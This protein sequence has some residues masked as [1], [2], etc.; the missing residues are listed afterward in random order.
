MSLTVDQLQVAL[1]GKE[2]LHKIQLHMEE[3]EFL[4]LIGAS[5]CGKTT[6]LKSIAGLLEVQ[7]GDIRIHG[8]SVLEKAPEKRGTVI[9]FQDLRLFPHMTVE[10]NIAFPMELKKTPKDVQKKRV[11]Q[12]LGEV[13][14]EGYGR[15]KIRELSG[16][17]MQR[18]ALARALAADPGILLLDE[19]FSGLDE[20]LRQEM[21]QLVKK[22]HRERKITTILV[23]H[24]KR[25][26]LQMS[27]RI[28]LMKDG[29]ILQHGTPQEIYF[30][31]VSRYAAEYFGKCNYIRGE[32][33]EGRFESRLF[34]ANVRMPDG[35]YDAMIRPFQVNLLPEGE[36]KIREV[37]FMG[38][39]AEV[40]ADTQAGSLICQTSADQ[41][42]EERFAPGKTAGIQILSGEPWLFPVLQKGGKDEEDLI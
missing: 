29:R 6:L 4:S 19:P 34:T 18:V 35:C 5:G 32:V 25:E 40:V 31:P 1:Q 14:L 17:Q 38:E 42:L 8:E 16:G 30:H 3:G 33:R 2:I 27:D 37:T 20:R 15:R 9:V 26:A 41:G 36:A 12:L 11:E 23:T 39:L 28:A 24:D 10:K 7:K 21:G 13:Q 22:L